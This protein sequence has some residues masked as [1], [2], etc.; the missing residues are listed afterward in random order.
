LDLYRSA[1]VL[2]QRYGTEDALL[3]AA[4]RADALLELG[5]MEGQKVW[6]GVLRAVKGSTGMHA[7][8]RRP[9]GRRLRLVALQDDRRRPVQA[10][11]AKGTIGAKRPGGRFW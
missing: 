4:K 3:M 11:D 7:T 5:D 6:K 10:A 1:N 2:I 9:V 8:S